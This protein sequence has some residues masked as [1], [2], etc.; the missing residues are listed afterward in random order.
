MGVCMSYC[1]GN[2]RH[3]FSLHLYRY[4]HHLAPLMGVCM[5]Y[6]TRKYRHP[7][8]LH[9]YWYLHH[10]APVFHRKLPAPISPPFLSVF[11][12]PCPSHGGPC[13]I[14]P[15]MTGTCFPFIS[16][17]IYTTWPLSWGSACHIPQEITGTIFP[18]LLEACKGNT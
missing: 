3:P 7:F 17:C 9:V 5:S 4:L 10:L 15:E 8:S 6:S 12:A 2:Y 18:P 13:H 14:P 16:I 11:R 1:T